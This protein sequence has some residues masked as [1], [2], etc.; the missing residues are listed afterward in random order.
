MKKFKSK[1]TL[2]NAMKDYGPYLNSGIQLA[3]TILLFTLLGWWIDNR[4]DT[5]PIWTL[6]LS[7]FGIVAG[8]YHFFKMIFN[9]EK[10]RSKNKGTK[11]VT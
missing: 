1:E 9:E 3:L 6:S 8:M 11:D 5:A 10:K 7:L 4:Y 2:S